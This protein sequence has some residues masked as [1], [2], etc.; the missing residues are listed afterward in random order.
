M[1]LHKAALEFTVPFIADH[2]TR[3]ILN[4][5]RIEPNKLVATNGDCLAWIAPNTGVS[6]KDF[7]AIPGVPDELPEVQEVVVGK[8]FVNQVIKAIPKA[9]HTMPVLGHALLNTATQ[10]GTVEVWTTDIDT[11]QSHAAK[12]MEGKYPDYEA[13]IPKDEPV[14]ETAIDLKYLTQVCQAMK[15]IGVE[16][17][18]KMSFY[19]NGKLPG[20]M[21]FESC[22]KDGSLNGSVLVMPILAG[23]K[24]VCG[25]NL[26][27]AR[28]LLHTD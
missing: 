19:Q 4:G 13:C 25:L 15:K 16:H 20:V 1:L 22:R 7:P 3:Y 17:A 10:N 9:K 24:P 28:K 21:I 5:L 14:Y 23:E 26:D 6:D 2:D 12:V 8:D 27:Q 18:V 11:K